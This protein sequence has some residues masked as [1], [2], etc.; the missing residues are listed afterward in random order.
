MAVYGFKFLKSQINLHLL[1]FVRNLNENLSEKFSAKIE[2]HK[3]D[4]L[5][6]FQA[7]VLLMSMLIVLVAFPRFLGRVEIATDVAGIPR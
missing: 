2:I 3:I 1:E 7:R 5:S 6:S 4:T